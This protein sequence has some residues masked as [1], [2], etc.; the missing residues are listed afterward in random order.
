VD[1]GEGIRKQ[2]VE[3]IPAAG[4]RRFATRCFPPGDG[5]EGA[6]DSAEGPILFG[7]PSAGYR[8][9]VEKRAGPGGRPPQGVYGSTP[10]QIENRITP[11]V[12]KER[13][14][15]P[16]ERG[17]EGAKARW[18]REGRT[19]LSRVGTPN[20]VRLSVAE[21]TTHASSRGDVR[22]NAGKSP[23]AGDGVFDREFNGYYL[24]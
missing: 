4:G 2:W 11:F 24:G 1:K 9:A 22:R 10:L 7:C 8:Y 14:K 6:T 15:G 12:G 5:R 19:V 21:S 13:E 17:R 18:G 3:P 20:R 16:E 23:S